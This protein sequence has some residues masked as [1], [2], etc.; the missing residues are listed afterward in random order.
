MA[1]GVHVDSSSD[2]PQA[3]V[4][5]AGIWVT[6]LPVIIDG[7]SYLEGVDMFPEEFYRRCGTFAELPKTSQPNLADLLEA[8]NEILKRGDEVISI[9]LSSGLSST[10]NTALLAREMC[11]DPGRVHVIDSKGAALGYG[12][13]ALKTVQLARE[14]PSWSE[15]EG[16]I[17]DFRDHMRYLFMPDT[18]EYL[19][20]GGRVSKTIGAIGGVLDIK[21]ILRVTPEG[22]IDAYVKVRSK[23]AAIRKVADILKEEILNPTE[24]VVGVSH[25]NCLSDAETLVAEI[26]ARV[27]V[28]D[29]ILSDIGCVVGSHTGPGTLAVFYQKQ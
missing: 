10:V 3:L 5:E 2:I 23:R 7:Q 24:Q 12:L 13:I 16:K 25:S 4:K 26:R 11:D 21:P 18:F 28:K 29:V 9:L 19:V 15:L 20:K 14:F 6:P 1:F 22:T 8:Y 17:N 27:T